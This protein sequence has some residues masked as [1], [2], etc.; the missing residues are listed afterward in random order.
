MSKYITRQIEVGT[1]PR[2]SREEINQHFND[3]VIDLNGKPVIPLYD[4]KFRIS[5]SYIETLSCQQKFENA[6]IFKKRPQ[7]FN[8]D[9]A[10]GSAVHALFTLS[11]TKDPDFLR[12][13]S[14]DMEFLEPLFRTFVPIGTEND[15]KN[16][17]AFCRVAST[18]NKV[19]PFEVARDLKDQPMVECSLACEIGTIVLSE[20]DLELESLFA[21]IL[22]FD[23]V[24]NKVV[25][26]QTLIPVEYVGTLDAVVQDA[27]NPGVKHVFD[28]KTSSKSPEYVWP[29]YM[30]SPAQIGYAGLVRGLHP[31][32]PE[33]ICTNLHIISIMK[34]RIKTEGISLGVPSHLIDSYFENTFRLVRLQFIALFERIRF[35]EEPIL[36]FSQ[37]TSFGKRECEFKIICHSKTNPSFKTITNPDLF[38]TDTHL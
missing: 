26:P 1:T 30:N 16:F 37:C 29:D 8:I 22:F 15:K 31:N 23:F 19:L 18:L 25:Q 10:F 6:L 38:V 2:I 3:V 13:I 24:K 7:G 17:H 9:L 11:W 20:L 35:N 28:I 12:Q 34:D 33:H 5:G 32:P 27:Q 21:S 4:G 14:S 36:N